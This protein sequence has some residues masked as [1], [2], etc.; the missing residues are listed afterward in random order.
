MSI[1]CSKT[2]LCFEV[3]FVEADWRRRGLENYGDIFKAK[4]AR[5]ES[6]QL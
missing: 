6:L 4:N 1:I 5:K 3:L 2:N